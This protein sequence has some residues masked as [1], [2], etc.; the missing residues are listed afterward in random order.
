MGA[1]PKASLTVLP[2]SAMLAL[3]GG[4]ERKFV[5]SA[6]AGKERTSQSAARTAP[7]V[8]EP[9]SRRAQPSTLFGTLYSIFI[10]NHD[11]GNFP[12][13]LAPLPGELAP[14]GD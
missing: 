5:S 14:S 10:C 11:P 4:K 6:Y 8:G 1:A 7:L 13:T 2:R 12:V 3:G 9:W